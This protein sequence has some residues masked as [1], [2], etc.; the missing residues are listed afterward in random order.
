MQMWDVPINHVLFVTYEDDPNSVYREYGLAVNGYG[1]DVALA[2]NGARTR[3]GTY[4]HDV[5]LTDM[6]RVVGGRKVISLSLDVYV[7]SI[8]TSNYYK[9]SAIKGLSRKI[10][11]WSVKTSA[12]CILNRHKNG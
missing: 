6:F 1:A 11:A 2:F 8:T 3:Y 12:S 10:T 5:E 9:E 7:G 4:S